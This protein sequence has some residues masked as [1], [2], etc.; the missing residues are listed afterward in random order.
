MEP[1]ALTE[2]GIGKRAAQ[3]LERFIKLEASGGIL[4]ILASIVAII[5]A[6]TDFSATYQAMLDTDLEIRLGHYGIQKPLILWINDGLMAV[7]FLL[8]GMEIKR[9][10]REGHL[11]SFRQSLLPFF[12]AVGGMVVP[13]VVYAYLNWG[14]DT[15]RGWAI[16]TA[17]DIAFALG[18]L[19][20]FGSRIPLGLK[21]F[22]TA[23]A[24]IDDLGAILIIAIFY[25]D[26]LSIGLLEVSAV[27]LAILIWMNLKNVRR[28]APYMVVGVIM[29]VAVLKSGVHATIAGVLLGFCIPL[30]CKD[31]HSPLRKL[32]HG[33]HP[34]V[35]YMIL[36]VFAFANAG[37]DF[38]PLA[39]H[40]LA[41]PVPLG[42]ALGL[43]FGKQLGI[44]GIC[45]ALIKAGFAKLP[46]HATW[47]EFYGVCIL[48]GIG[49][50][51][52]LFIAGLAFSSVLMQTETRLGILLGTLASALAGYGFL[53]MTVRR[54]TPER[55]AAIAL[56]WEK[57]KQGH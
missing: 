17:T 46:E 40:Q 20:L 37:V 6:N 36:P 8:V 38:R 47:K 55:R 26:H 5:F 15:L 1:K 4:L 49:F 35:A 9:E 25:T 39:L 50:T 31:G 11:A 33:L 22:L 52:S 18:I 24:V 45:V 19:A 56:D 51:M 2:G 42:I 23:V 3:S 21:V 44:F 29:W 7:F 10:M 30:K 54:Q 43:F 14:D 13:G 27:C 57:H 53:A 28:I 16:P 12:A 48:C 41:D 32:E 34:W